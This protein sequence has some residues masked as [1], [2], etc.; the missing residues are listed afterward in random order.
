MAVA[1]NPLMSPAS[2]DAALGHSVCRRKRH[3]ML[4]RSNDGRVQFGRTEKTPGV[5]HAP[6]IGIRYRNRHPVRDA[7]AD[8]GRAHRDRQG[9]RARSGPERRSRR[10]CQPLED[11]RGGRGEADEGGDASGCDRPRG[12]V[13]RHTVRL[14]RRGAISGRETNLFNP[15]RCHF[16]VSGRRASRCDQPLPER[17]LW[18]E[19]GTWRPL[20]SVTGGPAFGRVGVWRGGFR[21]SMS[22]CR[23]FRLAV[24]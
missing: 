20:G 10:R 23:P 6:E 12:G 22:V 15:L 11:H 2:E 1:R 5:D 17:I 14:S 7:E 24:P 4:T 19:S 13:L 16:R 3:C 18:F 9:H 8:S 21:L